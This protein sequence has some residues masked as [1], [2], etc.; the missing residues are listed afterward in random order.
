[1]LPSKVAS[2]SLLNWAQANYADS[3]EV[4]YPGHVLAK[5]MHMFIKLDNLNVY[6]FY[7]CPIK[8][9]LSLYAYAHSAKYIPDKSYTKMG[10]PEFI[11]F[12][13]LYIKYY[14]KYNDLGGDFRV[15]DLGKPQTGF[16]TKDTVLLDLR[17]PS[18]SLDI[19]VSNLNLPRKASLPIVN[20]TDSDSYISLL[21]DKD[22]ERIKVLYKEDYAFFE[23][24][25][26][27]FDLT[28]RIPYGVWSLS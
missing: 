23:S 15:I 11:D 21:T 7:R 8:R 19:L 17:N 4:L 28:T 1:M 18:Q 6:S 20:S 10:I 2:R 5:Q 26:I 14:Y 3:I 27:E 25:N 16:F 12:L 9:F 13:S 22:I 24:R